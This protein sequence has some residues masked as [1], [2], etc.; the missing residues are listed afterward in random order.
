MRRS[1]NAEP[2]LRLDGSFGLRIFR[3]QLF[4]GAPRGGVV[5]QI[6]LCRCD[7]EER[8]R[9]LGARGIRRDQRALRGDRCAIVLARVVRIAHPVLCRR[10]ER[11]LRIILYEGRE[12]GDRAHVV[13]ALELIERSVI[14]ALLGG[15][16]AYGTRRG[17]RTGRRRRRSPG[18]NTSGWRSGTGRRAFGRG[19][20]GGLEL[21]QSRV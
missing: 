4:E 16:I 15:G 6:R 1:T 20:R 7:I 5:V 18:R 2:L 9:D 13:A 19:L 8:I 12:V 14:G 21:A 17:Q 3:D 11:A 10:G